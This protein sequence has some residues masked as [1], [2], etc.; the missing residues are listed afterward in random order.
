MKVVGRRLEVSGY[1]VEGLRL[2]H[3][4][5]GCMQLLLGYL[6]E[7][8]EAPSD[9]LE[10]EVVEGRQPNAERNVEDVDERASWGERG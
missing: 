7:V 5:D 1:H 3:H 10:I 6:H 9:H 4:G 8:G 2:S